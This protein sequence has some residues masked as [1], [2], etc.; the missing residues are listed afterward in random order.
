MS[1]ENIESKLRWRKRRNRWE[2][3]NVYHRFSRLISAG[4]YNNGRTAWSCFLSKHKKYDPRILVKIVRMFT[5]VTQGLEYLR[6][7]IDVMEDDSAL[8][9]IKYMDKGIMNIF[10][11]QEDESYT[12]AYFVGSELFIVVG[13]TASNVHIFDAINSVELGC[14]GAEYDSSFNFVA[15]IPRSPYL[16][17]H[18]EGNSVVVYDYNTKQQF[19]LNFFVFAV[20]ACSWDGRYVLSCNGNQIHIWSV[21]Q[22]FDYINISLRDAFTDQPRNECFLGCISADNKY[23]AFIRNEKLYWY[24][25]DLD[26]EETESEEKKETRKKEIDK[27]VKSKEVKPPKTK[28]WEDYNFSNDF[29]DEYYEGII[30]DFFTKKESSEE[31]SSGEEGSYGEDFKADDCIPVCEAEFHEVKTSVLNAAWSQMHMSFTSD[32]KYFILITPS[33]NYIWTVANFI[34]GKPPAFLAKPLDGKKHCDDLKVSADGQ[35]AYFRYVNHIYRWDLSN[36]FKL[37]K[38]RIPDNLQINSF[39]LSPREDYIVIAQTNHGSLMMTK[40]IVE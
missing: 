29:S 34:G 15:A 2:N 32:G 27:R 25:I 28:R 8:K 16:L 7:D 3:D 37:Q 36:N 40:I 33:K 19:F 12:Q 30:K 1:K 39:D 35:Y 6:K 18:R 38:V 4:L 9:I 26:E 31:A 13:L 10:G 20:I 24:K 17:I 14:I 22:D 5:N 11:K 23:I 21:Y